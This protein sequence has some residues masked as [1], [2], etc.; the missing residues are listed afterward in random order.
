[1]SPVAGLEDFDVHT[2]FDFT[3]QT[4]PLVRDPDTEEVFPLSN[5]AAGIMTF[6]GQAA[7]LVMTP[8]LLAFSNQMLGSTA[9]F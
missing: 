2:I 3:R 7:C 9:D 6:R 5:L 1:M 8:S 4:V